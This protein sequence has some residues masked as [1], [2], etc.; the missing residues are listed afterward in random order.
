MLR[1]FLLVTTLVSFSATA[2]A[3]PGVDKL[4]NAEKAPVGVV[5]EVVEGDQFALDWALP[6][7]K[8]QSERLKARFPAIKIAVVTHGNEQFGLAKSLESPKAERIKTL[9]ASLSQSGTPV[10]VCG[11]HADARGISHD[12]FPEYTE[13][14]PSGPARIT[15]YRNEGYALVILQKP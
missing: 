8:A 6:H 12:I 7:I 13:V 9:A 15:A 5:F 1:V 10:H 4:L 11:G 2:W 3:S 14:A